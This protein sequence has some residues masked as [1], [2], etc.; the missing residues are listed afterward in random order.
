MP[1]KILYLLCFSFAYLTTCKAHGQDT[2]RSSHI[3]VDVSWA[4]RNIVEG[5]FR[6]SITWSVG[7]H[8]AFLGPMFENFVGYTEDYHQSFAIQGGYRIYPNKR[9]KTFNL[10]FE[11]DFD[12][13]TTRRITHNYSPNTAWNGYG[14][15]KTVSRKPA[16][17]ENSFCFG[18][19]LNLCKQIYLNT[20]FG[21]GFGKYNEHLT[22]EYWYGGNYGIGGTQYGKPNWYWDRYFKF[23][24]G[25]EFVISRNKT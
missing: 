2:S 21:A 7:K 13:V 3:G 6:P 25:Y 5:C 12:F 23:C 9:G 24:L 16:Y 4:G 14:S 19:R 1:V 11:Y 10:F 22:W 8:T 17:F 15:L 18:F 20:D